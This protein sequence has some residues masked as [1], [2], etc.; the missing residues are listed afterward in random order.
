MLYS[1]KDPKI[2]NSEKKNNN[3][4]MPSKANVQNPVAI[5]IH[6]CILVPVYAIPNNPNL[7]FMD[8]L[9]TSTSYPSSG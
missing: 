1:L 8:G 5:P 3:N 2:S 4:Q 9:D 6:Q 7:I